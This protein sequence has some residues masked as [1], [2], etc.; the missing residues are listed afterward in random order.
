M[1]KSTAVAV[2]EKFLSVGFSKTDWSQNSCGIGGKPKSIKNFSAVRAILLTVQFCRFIS[3][4]GFSV[5]FL[6]YG[7]VKSIRVFQS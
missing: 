6:G 5:S 4:V 1:K 7:L 2:H 3:A